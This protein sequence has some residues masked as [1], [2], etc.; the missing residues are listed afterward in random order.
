MDG[1]L[2][3]GICTLASSPGIFLTVGIQVSTGNGATSLNPNDPAAPD[4]SKIIYEMH[5][6]LDTD[7]SGTSDNCVS[8]TVGKQRLREATS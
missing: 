6:Y 5:Q 1:R 2:D 8:S 3:L 7:V 4:G